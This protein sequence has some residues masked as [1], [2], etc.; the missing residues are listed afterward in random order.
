M[1]Q[2]PKLL[3]ERD[4]AIARIVLNRPEAGNAVDLELGQAFLDAAIECDEDDSIRCVV[5]TANGRMFCVGGDI[6][7]F[8]A[9]GDRIG[10]LL[11]QLTGMAHSAMARLARM[12]KPLLT[13]ING[14]AAGIGLG[15]AVLGDIVIAAR[16][17]HFT[18]AYTAIGVTPDGGATWML[19]RLI[20]VRR[21]QEMLLLNK[22]VSADDAAAIGLITRAV[23][24]DALAEEANKL[25]Q[26]LA[27]SATQ[28]LARTRNLIVDG[29]DAGFERQM[30]AESRSIAAAGQGAEGREGIRAFLEKRRPNFQQ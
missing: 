8:G 2:T 28:A 18:A 23:D 30:E 9:A 19:P 11:K 29:L 10:V 27:R 13:V 7:S 22:R 6:S 3:L 21:A 5:L 16:S 20:G 24:D 25:A 4:G 1:T 14:P 26:T 17:A 12:N 15:L